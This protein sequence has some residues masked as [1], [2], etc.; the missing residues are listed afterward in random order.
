MRIV[1]MNN[2]GNVGKS[3]ICQQML[4]PRLGYDVLRVETLNTDGEATGEKLSAEDFDKIFN[5]ILSSDDVIV[6]IG[7][8]NISIFK[9]KIETDFEGAHNFIDYFLIPVTPDEKQ[10]LD[11]VATICDL[12][13]QGIHHEKIKLI[14]NRVNPKRD[15]TEQFSIIYN[16]EQLKIINYNIEGSIPS[17]ADSSLFKSLERAKLTYNTVKD[18]PSISEFNELISEKTGK[19]K[20]ELELKKFYKLG[21][22]AYQKQM[23]VAFDTLNLK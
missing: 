13:A 11:T 20:T 15:M 6:D 18:Y 10:Q 21:F 22:D 14:F 23:Q 5:K 17:I 9:T 12:D 7:A 3:T 16:S 1:V 4:L 19:E 8:S 2:S